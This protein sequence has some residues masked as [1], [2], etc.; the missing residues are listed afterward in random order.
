MAWI[1]PSIEHSSCSCDKE[2]TAKRS[3]E[4]ETE[5]N[6]ATFIASEFE[7]DAVECEGHR[8]RHHHRQ[9]PRGAAAGEDPQ[10]ENPRP[11][12]NG[13]GWR[14]HRHC[15]LQLMSRSSNPRRRPKQVSNSA[16][17]S[18]KLRLRVILILIIINS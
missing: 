13:S 9:G 14:L 8:S 11:R 15:A 17:A 3:V 4:R 7:M 6:G 12:R 10:L 16:R 1:L 2:C 18:L 5:F